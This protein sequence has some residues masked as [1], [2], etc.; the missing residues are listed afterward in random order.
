MSTISATTPGS[1]PPSGATH[2]GIPASGTPPAVRRMRLPV[3]GGHRPADPDQGEARSAGKKSGGQLASADAG[4]GRPDTAAARREDQPQHDGMSSDLWSVPAQPAS[5]QPRF[6]YADAEALHDRLTAARAPLM[7][8]WQAISALVRQ[9]RFDRPQES[10]AGQVFDSTATLA[11]ENLA[12]GL[13]GLIVN[14]AEPWFELQAAPR[15][16][17]SVP[18][19]TTPPPDVPESWIAEVAD[20]LRQ[21]IAADRARFYGQTLEMLRELVLFGTGV[22]AIE[23][24]GG[25]QGFTVRHLPLARTLLQ[26]DGAGRLSGVVRQLRSVAGPQDHSLQITQ[27]Q[28]DGSW[29]TL[30][31]DAATRSQTGAVSHGEAPVVAP[32]WQAPDGE[33]YGRSPAHT[34]MADIRTLGQLEKA[35]LLAVQKAVDPPLLTGTEHG[36][37]ALKTHPGAIIYGGLDPTG[38]R[39]FEP[40]TLTGDLKEA[41]SAAALRREQVREA[42]HFSLLMAGDQGRAATATEFRGRYEQRFRLLAPYIARLQSEFVLPAVRRMLGIAWRQG[43]LPRLPGSAGR[44]PDQLTQIVIRS[45][46][47]RMQDARLTAQRRQEEPDV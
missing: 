39:M 31:F 43:L 42:F 38:R 13:F 1:D 6:S 17:A 46:Y 9:T 16:A 41:D 3:S 8:D 34:A 15:P 47:A 22:L 24:D 30:V 7:Y 10:T 26:Q 29:Q 12:T 21:L 40:M 23:E 27:R 20:A 35:R 32:R 19:L 11:A 37:R 2:A 33:V 25:G 18:G 45:P 28:P 14:P 44:S 5:T 4:G 36:L